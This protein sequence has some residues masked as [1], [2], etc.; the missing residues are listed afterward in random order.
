MIDAVLVM[1]KLEHGASFYVKFY[2]PIKY[3]FFF[4]FVILLN[5]SVPAKIVAMTSAACGTQ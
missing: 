4:Y 1:K 5:S 3:Y 2:R